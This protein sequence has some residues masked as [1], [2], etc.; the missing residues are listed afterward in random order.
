[1]RA[2]FAA[3]PKTKVYYENGLNNFLAFEKLAEETGELRE[4]LRQF[5]SPGPHP[6]GRGVAGSGRQSVSPDL[7]HRLEEEVGDLFFVL[8][9]VARFLSVDPE[10]AL[11]SANQKFARRFGSIERALAAQG[12]RPQD[13]T[14][15]EMD[16]LWDAAKAEEKQR[17]NR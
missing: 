3:K 17:T 9:N 5:P 14:L 7:H 10:A 16:A 6:E 13:S 8:V 2:T 4:Q 11:R 15:A 1:M 12:K